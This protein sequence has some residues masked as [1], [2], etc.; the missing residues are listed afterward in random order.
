LE[1]AAL[2][3]EKLERFQREVRVETVRL[4]H[5][6]ADHFGMAEVDVLA[7]LIGAPGEVGG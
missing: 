7:A 6:A 3:E 1:W 2:Q 5:L 4:P